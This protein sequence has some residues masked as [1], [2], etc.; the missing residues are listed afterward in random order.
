M[1]SM[2]R[3]L[4]ARHPAE[5]EPIAADLTRRGAGPGAETPLLDLATIHLRFSYRP[6]LYSRTQPGKAARLTP[7]RMLFVVVVVKGLAGFSLPTARTAAWP[8]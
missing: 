5:V 7:D 8:A 4:A 2:P 6:V 3:D 1:S